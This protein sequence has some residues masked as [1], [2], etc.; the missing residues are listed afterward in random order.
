MEWSDYYRKEFM[1]LKEKVLKYH[2]QFSKIFS[3][4]E[5]TTHTA[6]WTYAHKAA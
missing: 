3:E 4:M 5:T 6:G 2:F 1:I